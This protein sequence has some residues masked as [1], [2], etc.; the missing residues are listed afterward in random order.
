METGTRVPLHYTHAGHAPREPTINERRR[1]TMAAPSIGGTYQLVRRELPDGTVQ[2][3]PAVKGMMTY[4]KTFRNFS[5]V[6]KDD[7]GK[8]YSECYVA[9]Y[10]LTDTEYAET[11]EYLI[12]DDQIG[13]KGISY[14]LSNTTA[15][16]AM[17]CDAG[18]IRFALPQPFEKALS[19]T[20]EFDGANL[21]ATGKDL[22]TDY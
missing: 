19:I 16:S 13:G 10:T 21:K 5:V 18:R 14:D 9:R 7:K 20:V 4:T 15:K 22:F 12:V 1:T 8:F 3:P 2:I 11:S 6:W 17:S